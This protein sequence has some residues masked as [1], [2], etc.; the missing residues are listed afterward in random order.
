MI[1]ETGR[2]DYFT[3]ELKPAPELLKWQKVMPIDDVDRARL[4]SDIEKHGVRDPLKCYGT[5]EGVFILGGLNRWE[6]AIELEIG[7]V[8]IVLYE[9]TPDELEQLVIDDNLNRRHFT[10][11]QKERLVEY[12]L[13]KD[14][15]Q[16]DRQIAEKTKVSPTTVGTQRKKLERRVQIGH[17][18]KRTDTKGRQQP[19]TK[20]T[21][22]KSQS[23][24]DL[25]TP[26]TVPPSGKGA[27]ATVNFERLMKSNKF[28]KFN[29]EL[30]KFF[31]HA[32]SG[33]YKDYGIKNH[34]DAKKALIEYIEKKLPDWKY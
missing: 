20:P 26:G 14:P 16:S 27:P 34:D 3:D 25:L 18:D 5:D 11:E 6:I 21:K 28:V 15:S 10:R 13:K 30:R 29:F 17:V 32:Y 19:A 2:Q 22:E 9:G 8:P 33:D 31:E 24:P 1:K 23:K 7:K 4:K 12:F